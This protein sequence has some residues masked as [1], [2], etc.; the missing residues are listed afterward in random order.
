MNIRELADTFKVGPN[1]QG[2]C[3]DAELPR[4]LIG[5]NDRP[6]L[7]FIRNWI[8]LLSQSA[9]MARRFPRRCPRTG[10]D[11]TPTAKAPL[12]AELLIAKGA[13]ANVKSNLGTALILLTTSLASI[14]TAPRDAQ[15]SCVM[16]QRSLE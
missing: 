15:E 7:P 13:D 14:T 9:P 11:V 1:T 4:T 10:T 6:S 3:K 12:V 8:V 16:L 5:R 2:C